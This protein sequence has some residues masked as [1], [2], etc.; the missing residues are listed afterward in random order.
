VRG[1]N[2][3]TGLGPNAYATKVVVPRT[4]MTRFAG[5]T[6]I[7]RTQNYEFAINMGRGLLTHIS[8]LRHRV[9]SALPPTSNH[10]FFVLEKRDTADG[11]PRIVA[12][13]G[14]YN[15][16]ASQPT[17]LWRWPSRVGSSLLSRLATI[18]WI[19][20]GAH[21][22]YRWFLAHEL[23]VPVPETSRYDQTLWVVIPSLPPFLTALPPALN[24]RL[25]RAAHVL[26][27]NYTGTLHIGTSRAYGG[28][29]V[30]RVVG[31]SGAGCAGAGTDTLMQLMMG[32]AGWRD[33]KATTPDVGVEPAAVPLV[34]VLFPKRSVGTALCL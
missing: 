8:T 15:Y 5:L 26:G 6:P 10:P 1:I 27:A 30:L 19:L 20:P 24:A 11:P 14:L 25:A 34:D 9:L 29:A 32:Y 3:H 31:G 2:R 18:R 33:L 4:R 13:A 21:P 16:N 28:G 7:D 22:P 23:A 12:G 17:A